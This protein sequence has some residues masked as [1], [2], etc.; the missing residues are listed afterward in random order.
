[1]AKGVEIWSGGDGAEVTGSDAE[2]EAALASGALDAIEVLTLR[3]KITRVPAGIGRLARLRELNLENTKATSVD[4]AIFECAAL[5][6]LNLEQSKLTTLPAGGWGRLARLTRLALPATLTALPDDLGDAAAIAG[7]L[8]LRSFAK[9]K[10]LPESVFRL[11]SLEELLL[12]GVIAALPAS[13][14]AMRSLRRLTI[15]GPVTKLP[16]DLGSLTAL[17]ALHVQ[18]AQGGA[19][20]LAA[21]PASFAQLTA[22]R[23]L[24]LHGNRL[25]ALPPVDRLSRL[26]L[27]ELGDNPLAALPTGLG[28]A[29]LARL[30]LRGTL[31]SRLPDDLAK[32]THAHVVLPAERESELRSTSADVLATL[33]HRAVFG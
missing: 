30:G 3:K 24:S 28:A 8:D 7:A 1:M 33:G 9:L 27:V 29:P 21:L 18:R 22:L 19:G 23:E 32:L 13:I 6:S 5:E 25:T 14:G 12:G 17:E 15:A 10:A 31:L 26:E 4:A 20:K 11:A 16:D 2:L